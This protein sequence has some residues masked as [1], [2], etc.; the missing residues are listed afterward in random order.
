M[1]LTFFH[2]I[3]VILNLF[4]LRN[5]TSVPVVYRGYKLRVRVRV[6]MVR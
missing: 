3:T 5:Q 1:L 6:R 4:Y 2:S